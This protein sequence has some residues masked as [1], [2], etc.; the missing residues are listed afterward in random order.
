MMPF[1]LI[2]ADMF[3]F[4][5]LSTGAVKKELVKRSLPLDGGAVLCVLGTE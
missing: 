5:I 1:Q 4:K 2:R 3:N